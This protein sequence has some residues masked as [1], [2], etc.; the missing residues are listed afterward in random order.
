[1]RTSP[2][3]ERYL[4]H[5]G[6]WTP[7]YSELLNLRALPA[8]QIVVNLSVPGLVRGRKCPPPPRNL[9][10]MYEADLVLCVGLVPPPFQTQLFIFPQATGQVLVFPH[11]PRLEGWSMYPPF[12]VPPKWFFLTRNFVLFLWFF[13]LA[14]DGEVFPFRQANFPSHRPPNVRS[15]RWQRSGSACTGP[16]HDVHAPTDDPP[17]RSSSNF[18]PPFSRLP[19]RLRLWWTFDPPKPPQLVQRF[20]ESSS[21]HPFPSAQTGPLSKT[22]RGFFLQV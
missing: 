16:N 3:L 17:Q 7:L 14:T 9:P 12:F 20:F 2:C 21:V 22:R 10:P 5:L 6:F 18:W 8:S 1:V 4:F 19:R 13:S 15:F 11:D